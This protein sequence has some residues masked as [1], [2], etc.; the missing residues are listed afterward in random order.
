MDPVKHPRRAAEQRER[1]QAERARALSRARLGME[2]IRKRL[3]LGPVAFEQFIARHG[4]YRPQ[5]RKA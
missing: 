1:D 3:G 4:I 5:R 2:E